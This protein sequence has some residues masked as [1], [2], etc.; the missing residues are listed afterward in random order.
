MREMDQAECRAMG[1][2]PYTA[3]ADSRK[4]SD[5]SSEEWH[6]GTL[7]AEWG[8][9]CRNFLTAEADVWMLSFAGMDTNRMWAARRSRQLMA[10]LLTRYL[11]LRAEVHAKHTVAVRWLHWLGFKVEAWFEWPTGEVFLVMVK[12]RS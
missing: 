11:S 2:D 12:R 1:V 4:R 10:D 6:N 3:L 5:Y 7:C 9:R 8:F